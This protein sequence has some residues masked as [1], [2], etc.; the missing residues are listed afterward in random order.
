[1]LQFMR[2]QRVRHDCVTEQQS[3]SKTENPYALRENDL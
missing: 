1:M 3:V 2:S